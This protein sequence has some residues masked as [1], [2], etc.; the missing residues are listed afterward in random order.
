MRKGPGNVYYDK[1]N[2]SVVI[3]DTDTPL[4]LIYIRPYPFDIALYLNNILIVRNE[5]LSISSTTRK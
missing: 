4:Q 1:W 2:I 5:E 3:C